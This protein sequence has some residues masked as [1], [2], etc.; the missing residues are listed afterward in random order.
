MRK[1]KEPFIAILLGV[2]FPTMMFT[3]LMDKD[4]PAKP[5]VP[6]T[7]DAVT[8]VP[9]GQSA[10]LEI[11]VL[12]EDGYVEVMELDT[13]ITGVVLKEMPASFE[14]EALMAQAVVARTYTLK[15][16]SAYK[17]DNAAICVD[18]SCCQAYCSEEDYLKNG[19]SADDLQKVRS[20]VSAT[21]NQVLMY[22]GQLIEATYFSCS[23]GMTEDAQAV[24]GEDIPYLQAVESPGEEGA[25]HYTDTIRIPV[26][27]FSALLGQQL[28]GQPGTWI[29]QVTYTPGGGVDT[30][31][32][33]GR[34]YTGIEIRQLL[35]LRSTAFVMTAVGN[36]V[37]VTTKGF[38]HRVGMSQY[39]ADAMAV[40]G[41]NY[42]EILNH[43]YPGTQLSAWP[44]H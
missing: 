38:G 2:V 24:W 32:I 3:M 4:I 23:G 19:G 21:E 39:G 34:E 37:T 11:P 35:G 1:W 12:M 30:I 29:K 26:D 25:S 18:Y 36:T 22:N 15:R 20:A 9:T 27:D 41:A 33:G 17:H 10:N 42:A 16:N 8:T 44:L 14:N 7:S 5:V 28:V 40:N 31:V 43:Y 6:A 13:Y